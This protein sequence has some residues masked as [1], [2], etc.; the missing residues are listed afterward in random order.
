MT[1][2]LKYKVPDALSKS[3]EPAESV[4]T[5]AQS[6]VTALEAASD[7]VTVTSTHVL[8]LSRSTNEVSCTVNAESD[9]G[10]G[11]GGGATVSSS[12]IVTIPRPS[13]I[14]AGPETSESCTVKVSSP[15]ARVSPITSRTIVVVVSPGANATVPDATMKSMSAPAVPGPVTH[16]T[17]I[18]SVEATS[19]S[20]V[21]VTV[22]VLLSPS[23]TVASPTD[24][25][26]PPGMYSSKPGSSVRT[27][28]LSNEPDP[29]VR[30]P[31]PPSTR[32]LLYP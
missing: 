12:M 28:T 14:V 6:T 24:T 31:K 13:S 23:V 29:S 27:R 2:A 15:S 10:G 20:T 5:V 7:S 19:S 1:P 22:V 17:V 9:A 26:E 25:R 32:G 4:D 18:G 8:P 3:L 11:G 21:T 16:P 30:I